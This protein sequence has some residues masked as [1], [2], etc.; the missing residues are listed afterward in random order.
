M[1]QVI[2][3]PVKRALKAGRATSG[4]WLHLCSPISAEIMG[5]AGFDWLLI[6]MAGSA[7]TPRSW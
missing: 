1:N 4:A 6:D 7:P 3:N 2:D 5:D